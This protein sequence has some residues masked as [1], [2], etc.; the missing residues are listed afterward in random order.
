MAYTLKNGR[1]PPVTTGEGRLSYRGFEGPVTYELRGSIS[2]LRPGGA[3]LR[4][5]FE[6]AAEI[7]SNAFRACDGRL[8]LADGKTY[9]ITMVGHTEGSGTAY[10][11]L[12]L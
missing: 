4:G 9:R 6:A 7:A 3:A 1:T 2:G 8:Q 5:A 11:E 12:R 10:F